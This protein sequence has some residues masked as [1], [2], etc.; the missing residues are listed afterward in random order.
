MKSN[1]LKYCLI[2]GFCVLLS[3]ILGKF[4]SNINHNISTPLKP[5]PVIFKN[6]LEEIAT[7]STV[8]IAVPGGGYGSGVIIRSQDK[9]YV[10]TT[11]HVVAIPPEPQN[12]YEIKSYDGNVYLT[13]TDK[14]YDQLVEQL[15]ADTLGDIDLALIELPTQSQNYTAAKLSTGLSESISVLVSGWQQC[16]PQPQYELTKGTILKKI[17]SES[18]INQLSEKDDSLYLQDKD[19]NYKNGY[20]VKYTNST[21]SGMSGGPVF[22]ENGSIVA[23]HGMPGAE[24]KERTDRKC[25]SINNPNL[26]N[27]WGIPISLFL[28]SNLAKGK[29]FDEDKKPVKSAKTTPKPSPINTTSSSDNGDMLKCPETG[30]QEGWCK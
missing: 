29:N 26:G 27:N 11:K 12:Q 10:L 30:K 25:Q 21:L 18:E 19:N 23:I 9:Y 4:V 15:V 24:G 20:R 14:N 22:N 3:F 7:K 13:I 2:I 28:E 16:Q 6:Q 1:Q 8:L 17:S 5:T